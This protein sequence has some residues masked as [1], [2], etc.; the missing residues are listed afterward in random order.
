MTLT[1][2]SDNNKTMLFLAVIIIQYYSW[3]FWFGAIS[4]IAMQITIQKYQCTITKSE[5]KANSFHYELYIY[6]AQAE[7][8][9]KNNGLSN[10]K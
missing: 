1:F 7:N 8:E 3:K 2:F 9:R 6:I 10:D 5:A 4:C